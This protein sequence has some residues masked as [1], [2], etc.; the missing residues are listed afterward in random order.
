[1]IWETDIKLKLSI[2]KPTSNDVISP[3]TRLAKDAFNVTIIAIL[4]L[5]GIMAFY[6]CG[7]WLLTIFSKTSWP[8]RD[9]STR[10]ILGGGLLVVFVIA[11][12]EIQPLFIYYFHYFYLC[13]LYSNILLLLQSYSLFLNSC[14]YTLYLVL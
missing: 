6:P 3:V 9:F 11:F 14:I 1:M 8:Q 10:Y 13:K 12:A 5:A 2:W 7:Q 4:V